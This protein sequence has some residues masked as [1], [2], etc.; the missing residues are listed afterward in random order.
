MGQMEA[1]SS[2]NIVQLVF[3]FTRTRCGTQERNQKLQGHH[4]DISEVEVVRLVCYSLQKAVMT[5]KGEA[6]EEED[7]ETIQRSI[8][9][10]VKKVA[11]TTESARQLKVRRTPEDVMVKEGAAARSTR[12]IEGKKGS[13]EADKQSRG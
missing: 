3:L 11:H 2:W 7:L 4:V 13:Q 6:Q 8:E 5:K 12:P 9:E 10:A 1:P